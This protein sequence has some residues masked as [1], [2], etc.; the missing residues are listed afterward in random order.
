MKW[1]GIIGVAVLVLLVI[2]VTGLANAN[3]MPPSHA[4]EQVIPDDSI[5]R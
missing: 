5:S 4:V 2:G 3:L 1:A